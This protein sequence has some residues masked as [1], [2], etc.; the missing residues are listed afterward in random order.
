[1]KESDA[2]LYI[3]VWCIRSLWSAIGCQRKWLKRAVRFH[4]FLSVGGKQRSSRRKKFA[5]HSRKQDG[6]NLHDSREKETLY[7]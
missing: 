5:R 1:M 7:L 2:L 6:A 3:Y 4:F